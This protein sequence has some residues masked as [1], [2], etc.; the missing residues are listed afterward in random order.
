MIELI[1]VVV[2]IGLLVGVAVPRFRDSINLARD[3]RAIGDLRTLS[4]ELNTLDSLP[5]TLAAIGRGGMTDPWGRLY[6]YRPFPPAP[7]NAPP[8]DARK[9]MFLVAVNTRYDLYSN[10]RDGGTQAAFTAAPA[11]DDIV[12]GNDGGYIGLARRY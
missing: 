5:A 6:V 2:I 7:G 12:V 4:Q 1:S 3:S 9:D 8:A 11:R 10:G